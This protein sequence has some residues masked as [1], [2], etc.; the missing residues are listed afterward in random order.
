MKEQSDAVSN[1]PGNFRYSRSIIGNRMSRPLA[2]IL[3]VIG[4][5]RFPLTAQDQPLVTLVSP[6]LNNTYSGSTVL[7]QAQFG[8]GA[9]PSTFVAQVNGIDITNMFSGTGNCTASGP[10]VEAS[11][12]D[13]DL[14]NG[15][16]IVTVGVGGPADSVGTGQVK[17]HFA[18]SSSATSGDV[19]KLIPAISIQ[20]VNLPASADQ[21]NVNS[22]QILLGPG[23]G[24]P[25]QIY[26]TAGLTCSA[27]INSAQVLV[28]TRQTLVPDT[29]VTGGTG[30]ACFGD[31]NSLNTF[32]TGLPKG[33]LVILNT[34][35][36]LMSGIDTTAMGGAKYSGSTVTPYYYNAI[37]VAGAPAET[38]F[39]SY[40]PNLNHSPRLGRGGLPPLIGSLMLDTNQNYDFVPSFYPEVSVV[41]G[42]P[43]NTN[44][45]SISY[46]TTPLGVP[47]PA[48]WCLSRSPAGTLG[49][50]FIITV[51]RLLGN[52]TDQYV[53][54]TNSTNSAVSQSQIGELIYLIDVYY[55]RNDLLIIT[56]FGTPIGSSSLVNQGLYF[57]FTD[58]LGGNGY[59]LGQLTTS[60]SAYTLISSPD[61]PYRDAH[62]PLES[63]TASKGT[64][65]LHCM[66]SKDRTNRLLMNIG[67]SDGTLAFPMGFGWTEVGFQQPQDWPAWTTGQQ[68][69]Y[70]DLTSSALHYPAIN[71]LLGCTAS[72]DPIRA[73]YDGGIGGTGLAPAILTFPYR[74]LTYFPNPNYTEADFNAVINQLSIEGGY[75][76]NV[77]LAYSQFQAVTA[78]VGN[79]LQAQLQEVV[80]TIDSSLTKGS[81]GSTRIAAQ[82]MAQAGAVASLFSLLPTVGPA[83][84]ALSAV[85]GAVAALTPDSADNIPDYSRYSFTITQL[86]NQASLVGLGIAAGTNKMFN[87]I[88]N[89]WGKLSIIGPGI[90]SSQSPWK[91]CLSCNTL[92]PVSALPAFALAA[93]RQFYLALLPTVYSTDYFVEI[94]TTKLNL[95]GRRVLISGGLRC[96]YPYANAPADA[97]AT[98]TSINKPATWDIDVITQ[99][100]M[101]RQNDTYN[102]LSFPS[103]ALLNDLF[104]PPTAGGSSPN[105]T[106]NGGGAG[107]LPGQLIPSGRYLPVRPAYIPGV[108]NEICGTYW[109]WSNP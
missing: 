44:C 101:T 74:T 22:Y 54:N 33:D 68:N 58:R 59:L 78:T 109:N 32:L 37:G 65:Q 71:A 72:C 15:I 48:T 85:L 10:C 83:F 40:Q 21:N 28:L 49:G 96:F 9:N 105:Y 43:V 14:L 13:V 39:E 31:P 91:M 53:L 66:L 30:Q 86:T 24:F 52:V 69:A 62:Y 26:T 50:F 46:T 27:G 95:I 107:L 23:P 82:R 12:P 89:D 4:L 51:D 79:S 73:Y 87:G 84:G 16:N 61:V 108:K 67:G 19:T 76:A 77:Y 6:V 47:S 75:E 18:P 42:T 97:I 102:S 70:A 104:N 38:A 57:A 55:K 25:Q 90:G 5:F 35:L 17:F 7:V 99:T 8:P 60:G 56:T 81:Y 20:S 34:F 93:K 100:A 36:G 64:G 103:T 94:P 2:G 80:G 92:V 41:P 98:Y 88:V 11:V 3:L 45:A 29:S 63:S 106:L 1:K